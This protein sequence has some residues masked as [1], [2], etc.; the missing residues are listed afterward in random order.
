M[1]GNYAGVLEDSGGLDDAASVIA[2]FSTRDPVADIAVSLGALDL[3]DID[4]FITAFT[5]GCP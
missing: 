2:G 5:D 4:T 1:L 3:D